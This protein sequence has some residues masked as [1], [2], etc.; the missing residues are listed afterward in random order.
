MTNLDFYTNISLRGNSVLVRGIKNGKDFMDR[1]PYQPTLYIESEQDYGYQNIYGRK[2]KPIAFDSIKEAKEF[3]DQHKSSNLRVYGMP[4]FNHQFALENYPNNIDKWEKEKIR[5]FNIDIEVTSTEGFPEPGDAA[6]PVTAICIH[7]SVLDKFIVFGDNKWD[8]AN[9]ELPQDILEKTKYIQCDNEMDLLNRF[10]RYWTNFPPHI[11]T[12]WNVEMF[13]MPYLINRFKRIGL[14]EKKFSPWGV[15][16]ERIIH[17]PRGQDQVYRLLG[18]DQIDYMARYKKN[19]I[20]ESYRLDFIA[21]QELGERKLDYSEVQGLHNLYFE[22]YQK[23]I[24]Y[25]IQDVNLVKRLDEKLGLLDADI[26]VA[27]EASMNFEDVASP[28]RTW[29]YLINKELA[30]EN[31]IVN[32]NIDRDKIVTGI[33]GGHVKE[34]HIGKH[35]WCMSFDLNSLYP[36]LIMQFNI[37]PETLLEG[38]Q[39]WPHESTESRVKKLLAKEPLGRVPE[40]HSIS[41]AGYAFNNAVEGIIPKLMSKMY[42]DRKVFKKKM[43]EAQRNG[44]D[45]TLYNLRQYVLKILLNSGYG[46]LI[47]K[48]FRWFDQRMGEAITLSGQYVIQVAER[49]LNLW[50][51]KVVG[52]EDVDYIIA[53]DTDS[54][55]ISVQALVD[56]F[57]KDKP[58]QEIV[59]LLNKIGQEQIEKVLNKGFEESKEYLQAYA[60]KMVMER[61]AIASSAFWTAKKR[62]AMCVWDMEGVRMA[63][64]KP[65]IKIQGLEAI[66][67]S[68]PMSCRGALLDIIKKSLIEDEE[69]VQKFLAE[70][71]EKFMAMPYQDIAM[72]RSMNNM[73]KYKVGDG[74]LKGT[75][76]QTRGAI[77][78]NKLLERHG[79]TNTWESI[80]EGEKGKFLYLREP[81]SIGTD[82]ISFSTSIPDEFDVE[83]YIDREKMFEKTVKDAAENIFKPLGWSSEKINTLEDFF[84]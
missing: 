7:D 11:I 64:D 43:L 77:Q 20:Q 36:H 25:N 68:T 6:F 24:D 62:Y 74:F 5:V 26:M 65:K 10:I 79:L 46:A 32:Y 22:N 67:S 37:S 70:F 73:S 15:V 49:E 81:N 51:N 83:K 56:K 13:D 60:Q 75:P 34:P 18:V 29:D 28:V 12:G 78:F 48:Y 41:G 21:E 76:P 59:E 44:E 66:R 19:K 4:A 55:Y 72:P 9:S 27:F 63:P 69:S 8:E 57:F 42:Q 31:K 40:N 47:N 58:Q 38:W 1:V 2:L 61:E 16:N 14:D 17:S 3:A 30:K 71:K 82:V 45:D 54:N 23:F 84:G 35:G 50:M 39:L 53:I 52:T 80:K 33:P